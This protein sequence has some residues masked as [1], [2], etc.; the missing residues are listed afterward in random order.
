MLSKQPRSVPPRRIRRERRL[1]HKVENPV[2]PLGCSK[3]PELAVCGGLRIDEPLFDCLTFCCGDPNSCDKVCRRNPD[4]PDRLREI[5]GFSLDNVPRADILH[6]PVL[7]TVV[8]IVFNR[9]RLKG[10]VGVPAACLS[11]YRMFDRRNG[12][13]RFASHEAL[14]EAFGLCRGIPIILTGTD[15]DPPLERWWGLGIEGRRTVIRSLRASGVVLVTT[16]NYSLFTDIPR[17]DDLHAMKRIAI[18]QQEFL[19]EG[20]PA[21]LHVNA[22]TETDFRR[23]IQYLEGHPEVTHIAYEFTTGTKRSGRREQHAA[24]LIDLASK[25]ERPL[26]LILRGGLEVLPELARTFHTIVVLD[27]SAFVKTIKRQRAVI[28]EGDQINWQSAPTRIGAPLDALIAH[29]V[30]VVTAWLNRRIVSASKVGSAA[31]VTR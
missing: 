6:S 5:N 4:Y 23:W 10:R 27:T 28:V 22:R 26:S 21:A 2:T 19:A 25:I 20:L 18:V 24:W 8:P 30:E 11:L 1:W 14:C 13:P 29:N 3:C 16:P 12:R 31:V 17:W 15:K 9:S 7:P